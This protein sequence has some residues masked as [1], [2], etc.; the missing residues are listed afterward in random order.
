MKQLLLTAAVLAGVFGSTFL[1]AN[2]TGLLTVDD[3]KNG[4]SAV[5]KANPLYVALIVAVVLFSDIFIAI[6]TLSVSILSGYFLGSMFGG[7]AA[8]TGMMLAGIAGYL[9]CWLYGPG[10]LL[11][12]YKDEDN[13]NRMR[14]IFNEHGISVLL[15]CRAMPILPEVCCCLSGANRMPFLKFLFFYS[16]ATVPYAFIAS[17]AGSKSTLADPTPALMTAVA[18]SLTLWLCWFVFLRRNSSKTSVC[19]ENIKI[20]GKDKCQV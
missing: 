16:S 14:V 5:D 7:L 2:L 6:P 3:I 11:K 4:L 10:L 9:I 18:V 13:L 20:V 1:I 15:M 12:I 8:A 17:Y 19:I